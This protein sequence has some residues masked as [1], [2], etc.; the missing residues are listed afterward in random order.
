MGDGEQM[1]LQIITT[2]DGSK[3]L[4][5]EYFVQHYH[6]TFGAV[7]ESQ[8]VFIE[9]GYLSLDN[10]PVSILETG[11]GT[12]LNAWLTLQQANKLKRRTRYEAIEL[13]P[14]D[15]ATARE[16][17]DDKI[18]QSLHNAPW[19]QPVEITPWFVLHKRRC[20]LLQAVFT[21]KFDIV[22]FDAFSPNAQPEMWTYD[23]FKNIYNAM[24]T[25]AILTTYCAKGEVRRT[26]QSVGFEIE[27]LPG[28]AGKREML[29]GRRRF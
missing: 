6:S 8:H 23:V 24:N 13:Y 29:R 17:S 10:N 4:Y 28:P 12:G 26:M 19:E 21:N 18:F 11:F 1:S 3:T 5:S 7:R 15:N 22:Y 2:C 20:D 27:R 16:L 25:N 9:A 14:I